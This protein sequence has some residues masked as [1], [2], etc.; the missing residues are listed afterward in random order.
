MPYDDLSAASH[1]RFGRRSGYRFDIAPSQLLAVGAALVLLALLLFLSGLAIGL[2]INPRWTTDGPRLQAALVSRPVETPSTPR[3]AH[4]RRP[5]K[6]PTHPFPPVGQT[7]SAASE[8]LEEGIVWQPRSTLRRASSRP[9]GVQESADEPSSPTVV[10]APDAAPIDDAPVDEV[11]AARPTSSSV[12]PPSSWRRSQPLAAAYWTQPEDGVVPPPID[13]DPAETSPDGLPEAAQVSRQ[14]APT[15]DGVGRLALTDRGRRQG[16]RQGVSV[17]GSKPPQ[18]G[19]A[20]D[21][22]D[23]G[24]Q[25]STSHWQ[26]FVSSLGSATSGETRSSG[27]FGEDG[28]SSSRLDGEAL[29]ERAP[30]TT[31]AAAPRASS[32]VAAEVAAD[33]QDSQGWQPQSNLWRSY[34]EAPYDWTAERLPPAAASPVLAS[35]SLQVPYGLLI[36]RVA[37]AQ[38]VEAALVAAM[39]QVESAFDAT[40]VS[41]K[42]ARGLMQVMPATAM[43]FGVAGDQLFD[44]AVNL[45]VG[46]RYLRWLH[47]RFAGDTERVLAAYN[48]GENAVDTYDGVPPYA[49]TQQY[50][51]RIFTLM[52]WPLGTAP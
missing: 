4:R 46:A 20:V 50:V 28:E 24:W 7:P 18:T 3:Q 17:A 23:L 51:E 10:R 8:W 43:R 2:L 39:V 31:V 12:R 45:E 26:S 33:F 44:P 22:G 15:A 9:G 16:P 1:L 47:E 42:G 32:S 13:P 34:L 49:E 52:G 19:P 29:Q 38:G 35:G 27:V 25:P 21:D 11:Y 5:E 36:D 14:P 41:P 40:A 6:P 48:A 30:T 37:L